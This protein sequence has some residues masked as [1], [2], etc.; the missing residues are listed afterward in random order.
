MASGDGESAAAEQ[1]GAGEPALERPAANALSSP[2]QRGTQAL[3]ECARIIRWHALIDEELEHR[4]REH[5]RGLEGPI[6]FQQGSVKVETLLRGRRLER[7]KDEKLQMPDCFEAR[8]D[9]R[10]LGANAPPPRAASGG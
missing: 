9:H 10:G 8:R 2:S 4:P 6:L 3:I 7:L 5:L 1:G